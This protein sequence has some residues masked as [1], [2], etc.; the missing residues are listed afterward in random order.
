[1]LCGHTWEASTAAAVPKP[2]QDC[3]DLSVKAGE[4]SRDV[5]MQAVLC[6][7]GDLRAVDSNLP[8]FRC[9]LDALDTTNSAARIFAV[10]AS[11]D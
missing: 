10:A 5:N 8:G 11:D 6:P 4:R 9:I 7:L 2:P 3:A 1:M